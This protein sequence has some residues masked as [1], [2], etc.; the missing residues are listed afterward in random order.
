MVVV[1]VAIA[2]R[3]ERCRC[4]R[5]CSWHWLEAQVRRVL[6]LV[7][8][9]LSA[10]SASQ[11]LEIAANTL[12][13]HSLE[14]EVMKLPADLV[15]ANF[16]LSVVTHKLIADVTE[17]PAPGSVTLAD[18]GADMSRFQGDPETD[19]LINAKD[20]EGRAV[21]FV[22]A[23]F[24]IAEYDMFLKQA[25]VAKALSYQT[26]RTVNR[27]IAL[28]SQVLGERVVANAQLSA[29][30]TR[31]LQRATA[32][33]A[34]AQLADELKKLRA[35]GK[36]LAVLVPRFAEQAAR[37]TSAGV[38]LTTSAS[39]AFA[40]SRFALH[41]PT[42]VASLESSLNAIKAS[43]SWTLQMSISLRAFGRAYGGR[44]PE[45]DRDDGRLDRAELA[46]MLFDPV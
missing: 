31:A 28:S 30:V 7:C 22:Y 43:G 27:M 10:C 12:P 32:S 19:F 41:L 26:L 39:G 11:A 17:L 42:V 15:Q 29:N 18:L 8:L 16:D 14:H 36:S 24:G 45:L 44:H 2:H 34:N 37:L 40:T 4:Q 35:L 23:R 6:C 21:E 25:V 9:V 33:G 46:A 5:R 13:T 3:G 38:S 20:E 1:N